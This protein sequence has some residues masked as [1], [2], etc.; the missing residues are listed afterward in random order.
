M[1]SYKDEYPKVGVHFEPT[2]QRQ[3]QYGL[4]PVEIVY[5]QEYHC[6]V[7]GLR[8]DHKVATT[9]CELS[10]IDDVIYAKAEILAISKDGTTNFRIGNYES[11]VLTS[12]VKE[13]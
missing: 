10:L 8:S 4:V 12:L 6:F 5:D 9:R 1:K 2:P 3:K 13:L 11:T 7:W